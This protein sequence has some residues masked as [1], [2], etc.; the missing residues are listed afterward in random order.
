LTTGHL[1]YALAGDL[2]AVPF[3]HDR[4]EIG[5][6]P[7]PLVEDVSPALA[8]GG[9][10]FDISR[11]GTLVY[12]PGRGYTR[13]TLVWVDREGREESIAAEP[14]HY[15]R[16]RISP[17][18]TRA[19]LDLL[20][21]E[22]DLWVW[23]FARETLTRVTFDPGSDGSS[24]W[25]PDGE[26]VVFSSNRDG[27]WNLYRRAVDGTGAVERLAATYDTIRSR[28]LL[29]GPVWCWGKCPRPARLTSP[30]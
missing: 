19:V 4:L 3:D 20:D 27:V 13:R 16:A 25:M 1:V 23:D 8:T 6:G 21:E 18:G 9:A 26:T 29:T 24:V 7:I 10:N 30:C 22:R 12:L 5:G 11:D 2:L 28:S 14:R 15:T 17:D